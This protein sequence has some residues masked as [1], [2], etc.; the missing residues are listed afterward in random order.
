MRDSLNPF[1]FFVLFYIGIHAVTSGNTQFRAFAS[2]AN[3]IYTAE[4]ASYL[5]KKH[6]LIRVSFLK[7]RGYPADFIKL[8]SYEKE[9]PTWY[10]ANLGYY[11]DRQKA[12]KMGQRYKAEFAYQSYII[13]SYNIDFLKE[14]SGEFKLTDI[15]EAEIKKK[16]NNGI[17]S[18]IKPEI[19]AVNNTSA[20]LYMKAPDASVLLKSDKAY[21]AEIVSY[22]D[23][24]EALKQVGLLR[25]KGYPADFIKLKSSEEGKIA[26]YVV[27]LGYYADKTKAKHSGNKYK[28][29]FPNRSY[30]I[31]SYNSDF[32]KK[33]AGVFQSEDKTSGDIISDIEIWTDNIESKSESAKTGLDF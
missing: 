11:Q 28:L 32:L 20:K 17:I 1:I 24:K 7:D 14:R 21:I 23:K 22:L 33:R 5:S 31:K 10:V 19:E 3:E 9:G 26:W 13:K 12:K 2:E 8:K 4:V 27:H 6:V 25:G 16:A 30:V 15:S 18:D 29:D